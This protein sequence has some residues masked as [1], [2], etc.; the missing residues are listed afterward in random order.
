MWE[1]LDRILCRGC[2]KETLFT[3]ISD[4]GYC[5]E[6]EEERSSGLVQGEEY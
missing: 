2:D 4:H 3:E 5:K 6:C 1:I